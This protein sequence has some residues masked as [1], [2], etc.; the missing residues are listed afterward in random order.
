M[1]LQ[2]DEPPNGSLELRAEVRL[3]IPLLRP[4]L[5]AADG[6]QL[7]R[8]VDPTGLTCRRNRRG[9]LRKLRRAK[10]ARGWCPAGDPEKTWVARSRPT[11]RA[12]AA[13]GV[14]GRAAEGGAV[15]EGG[16]AHRSPCCCRGIFCGAT[17]LR[18]RPSVQCTG[19][20]V[21]QRRLVDLRCAS[22]RSTS[23]LLAAA[24]A[25]PRRRRPTAAALRPLALAARLRYG[26]RHHRGERRSRHG[27]PEE[28]ARIGARRRRLKYYAW[29]AR[30][31]GRAVGAARLAG[32]APCVRIGA[33]VIELVE[34]LPTRRSASTRATT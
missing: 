23:V 5:R 15:A 10:D 16:E 34:E 9:A 17:E 6:A 31:G 4:A 32:P 30:H 21:L 26:H 13:A 22:P 3:L 2:C 1:P 7:A 12:A 11:P 14:G 25:L 27:A 33:Q 24:S 20:W 18:R 8:R 28:T 29:G 19:A